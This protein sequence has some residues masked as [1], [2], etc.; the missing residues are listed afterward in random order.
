MRK[1]TI[2]LQSINLIKL[3]FLKT[4]SKLK[5]CEKFKDIH[6]SHISKEIPEKYNKNTQFS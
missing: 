5:H 3:Q 1:Y 6:K 4:L 2:L